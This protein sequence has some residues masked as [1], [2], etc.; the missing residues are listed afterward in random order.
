M[1]EQPLVKE[2]IKREIKKYL[3]TNKKGKHN[4]PKL[5]GCNT[6]L[7]GK[8]IVINTYIKKKKYLK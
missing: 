4:I 6:A 3:E 5:M 8:F 1:P 7:R 2:E